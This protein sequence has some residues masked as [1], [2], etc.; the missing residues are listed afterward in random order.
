M[1]CSTRPVITLTNLPLSNSLIGLEFAA[2]E[3]RYYSMS[4]AYLEPHISISVPFE[5]SSSWAADGLPV[6]S[7]ASVI[8]ESWALSLV[9]AVFHL[10]VGG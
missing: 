7:D 1:L 8:A 9:E 3:K 5:L 2:R 4:M 6:E 10:I